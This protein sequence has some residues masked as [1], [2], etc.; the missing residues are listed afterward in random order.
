MLM[1]GCRS[2]WGLLND[3]YHVHEWKCRWDFSVWNELSAATDSHAE[4][5][6]SL[7]FMSSL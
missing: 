2:A 4:L 1:W 6:Y 3:Q 7:G 5:V